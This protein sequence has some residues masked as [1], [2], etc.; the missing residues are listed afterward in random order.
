MN[1]HDINFLLAQLKEDKPANVELIQFYEGKRAE[2][3]QTINAKVKTLCGE[4][5]T[6]TGT[7]LDKLLTVVK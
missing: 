7:N 5:C 4:M 1:L 6:T 3:I 2:L